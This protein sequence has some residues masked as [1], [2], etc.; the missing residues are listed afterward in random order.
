MGLL[1]EH[2]AQFLSI[3]VVCILTAVI[4]KRLV[5]FGRSIRA[6]IR[7]KLRKKR[8]KLAKP[9]PW[10]V[11]SY[12]SLPEL[13]DAGLTVRILCPLLQVKYGYNWYVSSRAIRL[14]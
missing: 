8:A 9:D 14:G 10:E 4:L 2:L 13:E 1:G 5:D 6:Y 12:L 11:S 3:L 7:E